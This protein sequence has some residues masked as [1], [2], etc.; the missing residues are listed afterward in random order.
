MRGSRHLRG[1]HAQS[2]PRS[3]LLLWITPLLR[4]R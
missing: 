3:L 2:P 4:G 1:G